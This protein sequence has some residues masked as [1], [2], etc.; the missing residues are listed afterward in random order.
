[1]VLARQVLSVKAEAAQGTLAARREAGD[2]KDVAAKDLKEGRDPSFRARPVNGRDGLSS[3]GNGFPAENRESSGDPAGGGEDP[4][5]ANLPEAQ[6]VDL[7]TLPDEELMKLCQEADME[8][9]DVLYARHAGPVMSFIH[10]M[11]GDFSRTEALMQ[12]S[13]L[14]IFREAANYQYPRSFS[15]WFY[16]IVRN[17]CK[18][19]LRYRSRHPTVS[20]EEPVSGEHA[21]G[22]NGALRIGDY[23][24]ARTSEPLENMLSEEMEKRLQNALDSLPEIERE[25]LILHRF[26]GLKYREISEIVGV[27]V[28]TVRSRMH[29]AMD[30]LRRA[31]KDLL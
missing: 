10:R 3:E 17:L 24:K 29:S 15:T 11:I 16:T 2:D 6:E 1:M 30:R 22:K 23:L 21:R 18:N 8:A 12:E 7:K 19:E 9:F 13:F 27:P 31:V 28:G 5:L 20:L 26:Q 25:I 14:R 4:A